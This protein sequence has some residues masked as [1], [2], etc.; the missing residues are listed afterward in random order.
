MDSKGSSGDELATSHHGT[1]GGR[2]H[3]IQRHSSG[4]VAKSR[5]VI[6][7]QKKVCDVSFVYGYFDVI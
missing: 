6:Q 2:S 3:G 5:E 1:T 4:G 7:S